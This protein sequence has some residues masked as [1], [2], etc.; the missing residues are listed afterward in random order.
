MR[1]AQR[2]QGRGVA[3]RCGSPTFG[4]R[5]P[6]RGQQARSDA[7]HPEPGALGHPGEGSRDAVRAGK[8]LRARRG[9]PG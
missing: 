2:S 9:A 4:L 5:A 7:G 1:S 8:V 3:D 6:G